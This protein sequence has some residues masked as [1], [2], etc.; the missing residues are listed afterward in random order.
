MIVQCVLC[1]HSRID[2][3]LENCD[4]SILLLLAWI[5]VGVEK[6]SCLTSDKVIP[7]NINGLAEFPKKH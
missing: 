6:M 5:T 1:Q 2:V 3:N 7:L 4:E